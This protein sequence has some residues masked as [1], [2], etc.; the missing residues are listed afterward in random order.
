MGDNSQISWTEATWNPI[1]GCSRVS[2]GCTNCYAIRDS[3]R[4]AGN[5][6]PKI[7]PVYAGLTREKSGVGLDWTGVVRCLPERLD[8]PL[9]WARPRRIFVNSMSDLFHPSVPFEFIDRVF[10]LMAMAE[11]HTFQVLTKRP[12]RMR[13]WATLHAFQSDP[14]V[15]CIELQ[16]DGL[17]D[18]GDACH[19]VGSNGMEYRWPLPNVWLGTSVEDQAAADVRIPELIKTPAAVRF[20]SCEPLLGL[21]DLAGYSDHLDWVICGGESGGPSERALV[22]RCGV[23]GSGA[24]ASECAY[25][26]GAPWQP[27]REALGWVRGLLNQCKTSGVAFYLKQWGGPNPKAGG[28]ELDGRIWAEYPAVPQ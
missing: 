22:Q 3:H 20:L 26:S 9:R 7:G 10:A 14:T 12:E 19:V 11:Q 2:D 25:C 28:R 13:E 15:R 24:P 4:L 8:I 5:P 17:P 1:V 23:C 18:G 6:N 21:V 27:K 16:L